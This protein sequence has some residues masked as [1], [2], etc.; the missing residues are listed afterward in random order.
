MNVYNCVGNH[1]RKSPDT[2]KSWPKF[3]SVPNTKTP[4]KM[5]PPKYNVPNNNYSFPNTNFTVPKTKYT[6][7]IPNAPSQ[8]SNAHMHEP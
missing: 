8:F 1:H 7:A 6:I 2:D 3:L 4:P 5:H